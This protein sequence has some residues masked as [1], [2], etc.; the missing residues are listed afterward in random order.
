[1]TL[2]ERHQAPDNMHQCEDAELS[3]AEA[4]PVVGGTGRKLSAVMTMPGIG[5]LLR[6]TVTQ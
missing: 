4:R 3:V 5:I 6:V 1:M 2:S